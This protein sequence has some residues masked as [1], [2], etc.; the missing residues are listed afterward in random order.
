MVL[1]GY[2]VVAADT[3][4]PST[5]IRLDILFSSRVY[6]ANIAHEI[7]D[8][9]RKQRSGSG[10]V[11]AEK[12]SVDVP[13][14]RYVLLFAVAVFDGKIIRAADCQT[15]YGVIRSHFRFRRLHRSNGVSDA[16]NLCR[17]NGRTVLSHLKMQMRACRLACA[18]LDPDSIA[19]RHFR[20][21]T[22][23]PF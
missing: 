10:L 19:D 12:S 5:D 11:V 2:V 16:E 9:E 15:V 23:K 21:A 3:Q 6:A 17:V 20:A 8:R 14:L 13:V 7:A 18:A 22:H 1:R 4:F